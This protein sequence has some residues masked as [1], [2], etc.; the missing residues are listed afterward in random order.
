[1]VIKVDGDNNQ[2]TVTREVYVLAS[3][4][5]VRKAMADA[6][7]PLNGTQIDQF[8]VRDHGT[9]IETVVRDDAPSFRVPATEQVAQ[10]SDGSGVREQLVEVIKPSFNRELR[11]VLS[12]G[13]E[14]RLGALMKDGSFLER[15]ESGQR[16]FGKG[17]LLRVILRST[18]HVGPQGLHTDYEVLKVIDEFDAPRQLG[19]LL[20]EPAREGE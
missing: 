4:P 18:P 20:P 14:G 19:G 1:V 10:Q 9:P 3:S 2:I 5:T 6:L 13:G 17:D 8:Q 11:W 15:V 12:D 16:T 7:R